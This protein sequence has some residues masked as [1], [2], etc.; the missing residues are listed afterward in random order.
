MKLNVYCHFSVHNCL[1]NSA[2]PLIV[3]MKI[4]E[5]TYSVMPVTYGSFMRC[6][7]SKSYNSR[8]QYAFMSLAFTYKEENHML[9]K[10]TW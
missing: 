9:Q 1:I 3:P 10:L 7:L 2:T 8:L 6:F 5:V 4:Y